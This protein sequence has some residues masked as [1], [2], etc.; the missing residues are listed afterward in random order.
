LVCTVDTLLMCGDKGASKSVGG[1]S[2]PY[3]YLHG[4]PLFI[5]VLKALGRIGRINRIFIIGDKQRIDHLLLA[6]AR[7][8]TISKPVITLTFST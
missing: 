3:L 6:H 5:H 1:E 2:K 4:I 7:A 8:I